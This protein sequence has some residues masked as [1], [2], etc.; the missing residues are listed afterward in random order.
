MSKGYYVVYNK[1]T[2]AVVKLGRYDQYYG[3]GAAKA[4]I[5]REAKKSLLPV[6]ADNHPSVVLAVAER[7][8]Y[9]A[10]IEQQVE[11][12]N[13]VTGGKFMESVNTPYFCS[14]SSETYWS[15]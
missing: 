13:A 10:N 5:T 9:F 6:G 14:P 2:T 12:V 7:S 8:D 11:R 15:M 3:I 4:A 1:T